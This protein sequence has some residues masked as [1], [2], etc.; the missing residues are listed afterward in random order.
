MADNH[1]TGE[2]FLNQGRFKNGVNRLDRRTFAAGGLAAL[3]MTGVGLFGPGS[4]ALSALAG[5]ALRMPK[6]LGNPTLLDL[7]RSPVLMQNIYR[8]SPGGQIAP[9]GSAGRNRGGIWMI[10]E[11]RA[12]GEY[13]LA[14]TLSNRPEWQETGWRVLDWGN[15]QQLP[16]GE[17]RSRGGQYHSMG[18]FLHSLELACMAQPQAVTPERLEHLYKGAK[19]LADNMETGFKLNA[20]YTHRNFLCMSVIGRAAFLT[21]QSALYDAAYTWAR[22]GLKAQ[23]ASGINPEAGGFDLSYQMVGPYHSLLFMP[24]CPDAT[25]KRQLADMC[26]KA[27]DWWCSRQK[28]DGA[29]DVSGSSRIGI[30]KQTDGRIKTVNYPEA[31]CT[32]VWAAQEL[33]RPELIDNAT[34]AARHL[35]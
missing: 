25:L 31:I 34:R 33:G 35:R 21:G 7:C 18:I 2:A 11:Q 4:S 29:V 3:G 19:W 15:A 13:V 27:I 23:L 10:E 14:G 30:E 9:D 8:F 5:R 12:G 1:A 17:Y 6:R 26:S 16:S 20:P 32:L 22:R 24:V 28:P